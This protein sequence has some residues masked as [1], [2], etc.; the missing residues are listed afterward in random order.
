[1][2]VGGPFG[3]SG[4]T[5]RRLADAAL[6]AAIPGAGPV[7][8]LGAGS[9][10]VTQAL[11][12]AGCPAD[13]IVVVERD[14][15]LCRT[16]ERRFHGLACAARRCAEPRWAPGGRRRLFGR[17]RAE[18]PADA[19]RSRRK[20]PRTAIR[21]PSGSCRPA[22]PSSS[23]PTA[24]SRRSIRTTVP[25]LAADFVG[26]EWRNVPPMGI[27][28]YRLAG[29]RYP[30]RQFCPMTLVRLSA[31]SLPR[32]AS[33]RRSGRRDARCR[34]T[35][36]SSCRARRCGRAPRPERP[37]ASWRRDGSPATRCR[38]G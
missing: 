30:C 34:P 20:P 19:C 1:M 32:R 10:Q 5:A 2:A 12:D 4:W 16:L 8:E 11:L 14:A 28:R 3:S 13:E 22:A 38:R 36:G 17:R 27:W 33:D 7:L 24:S 35:G 37:N 25:K 15:D 26:R 18:R 31:P 21:A 6:D 23:T 9:G 29:G